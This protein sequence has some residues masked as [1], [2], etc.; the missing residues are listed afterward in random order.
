MLKL[1]KIKVL[2]AWASADGRLSQ[3]E[4]EIIRA[5]LYSDKNI[6]SEEIRVFRQLQEKIWQGEIQI[7]P[8]D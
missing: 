3:V 1:E 7:D 4:S 6:T 5:T 2:I 8:F